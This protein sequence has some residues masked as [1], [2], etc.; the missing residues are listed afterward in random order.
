M[1]T[2]Q[3]HGKT[4]CKKMQLDWLLW[5]SSPVWAHHSDHMVSCYVQLIFHRSILIDL[6]VSKLFW[7][8]AKY[9]K[10]VKSPCSRLALS[11]CMWFWWILYLGITANRFGVDI[12]HKKSS[13]LYVGVEKFSWE[14]GSNFVIQSCFVDMMG[15]DMRVLHALLFFLLLLSGDV[16]SNP[17]PPKKGE[18][19][20]TVASLWYFK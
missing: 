9:I 17:G 4:D 8:Y 7:F 12:H 10:L 19:F 1:L 13:F 15:S 5:T 3:S 2:K 20:D 18:I 16:E 6:I 11:S 14:A